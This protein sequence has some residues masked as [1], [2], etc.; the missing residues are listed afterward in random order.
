MYDVA[1][2]AADEV[3]RELNALVPSLRARGIDLFATD[4][5]EIKGADI[6]KLAPLFN[7][8]RVP[9]TGFDPP[10]FGT[11]WDTE[12]D[13]ILA[14]IVDSYTASDKA[15]A[16]ICIPDLNSFM[17]MHPRITRQ[18]ITGDREHDFLHNRIKRF[19]DDPVGLR[20]ARCLLDAERVP[21]RATRTDFTRAGVSLEDPR[22]AHRPF[23]V[24]SRARDTGEV[25]NDLAVPLHVD[26]RRWGALRVCY[27]P[28]AS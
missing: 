9:A 21:K 16:Y 4:Y 27:R 15:I 8:S 25:L 17:T 5:R 1:A 3:E 11:S 20:A 10:K 19:F 6:K 13:P 23:I 14:K 24:Q 22:H 12:I 26:G 28:D 18:D 2:A 7:V